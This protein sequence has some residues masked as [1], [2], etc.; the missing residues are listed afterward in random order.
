MIVRSGLYNVY[1]C[2][3]K[4]KLYFAYK[5]LSLYLVENLYLYHNKNKIASVFIRHF[6]NMLDMKVELQRIL[7]VQLTQQLVLSKPME[8]H[9]LLLEQQ[10]KLKVQQLQLLEQKQ[11]LEVCCK[12]LEQ[13][14]RP[15]VK[16]ILLLEQL[17]M[18]EV[19]CKQLK[20]QPNIQMDGVHEH[21]DL[22][23]MHCFQ[24]QHM[25]ME[26][27]QVEMSTLKEQVL[28]QRQQR[29]CKN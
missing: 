5:N 14:S 21:Y 18:P 16:L 9:K 26:L 3:N 27:Q 19:R 4:N 2:I 7:R 13:Q 1:I 12:Q 15:K 24:H 22:H 28:Q 11:M 20:Q 8:M 6:R 25:L 23:H 10:G 17:H 29:K